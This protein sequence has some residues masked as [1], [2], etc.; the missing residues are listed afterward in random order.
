M[1]KTLIGLLSLSITSC[2]LIGSIGYKIQEGERIA[3]A[4][5]QPAYQWEYFN[6]SF[7]ADEELNLENIN[8]LTSVLVARNGK[9][10]L[11]WYRAGYDKETAINT[12]S[13]SK[14]V[15]SALIGIALDK[16]Y[17]RS[18][19][20]PIYELLD[21]KSHS[22]LR[23]KDAITV[24]HLLTMSAGF[25]YQENK[26]N[27]VYASSNWLE[28]ILALELSSPPGTQFR[29]GSIQ[30]HLL[31][32][33]IT[34]SSGMNTFDFAQKYLFSPINVS[35][36]AWKTSPQG[37]P[38]GGSQL[39]LTPRDLLAFGQ[40]YLNK[41]RSGDKQIIP[42]AWVVLSIRPSFLNVDGQFDYGLLWWLD[43][44]SGRILARGYGNQYMII[45]PEKNALLLMTATIP[46]FYD[47]RKREKRFNQLLENVL[48]P[49]L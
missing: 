29:Y 14:G 9:L 20:Q 27:W 11:E 15:V 34:H 33:I 37:I 13:M 8:G 3:E 30:T 21:I 28:S 5:L 38:F 17:I 6:S 46:Y 12:K 49:M 48:L 40:L 25:E 35:I 16:G 43:T 22:Q 41:G 2:S 31:S 19:D 44:E 39:F 1:S 24:R 26:D 10:I 32:E 45:L 36:R 23:G 42:A 18:I 47:W 7:C 4:P